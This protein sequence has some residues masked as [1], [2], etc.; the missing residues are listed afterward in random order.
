[1]TDEPHGCTHEVDPGTECGLCATRERT[2]HIAKEPNPAL[3]RR[4]TVT[5]FVPDGY[6]NASEFLQ[7][8]KFERPIDP[9]IYPGV[10]T[11]IAIGLW[12]KFAPV[13]HIEWYGESHKAEYLSAVDDI[14]TRQLFQL[15]LSRIDFDGMNE[16][17]FTIGELRR[18][19]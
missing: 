12:H 7:D 17:T 3:Q 8:C 9:L 5:I 1:M 18:A 2:V 6:A 11:E 14:T 16:S 13:H 4:P 19:I 10:R 15:L